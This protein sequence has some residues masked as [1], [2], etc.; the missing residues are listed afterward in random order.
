MPVLQEQKQARF[1]LSG[2]FIPETLI[3]P[4]RVTLRETTGIHALRASLWLFNFDPIKIV[5][6]WGHLPGSLRAGRKY[7]ENEGHA[8][9]SEKLGCA[10][11]QGDMF[12]CEALGVADANLVYRK[13]ISLKLW[14]RSGPQAAFPFTQGHDDL[15]LTATWPAE[16]SRCGKVRTAA[17]CCAPHC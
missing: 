4:D 5:H 3:F 10:R 15:R 2:S 16:S 7:R 11:R 6:G 1:A 17:H 14:D 8:P 13:Q 9:E 12:P